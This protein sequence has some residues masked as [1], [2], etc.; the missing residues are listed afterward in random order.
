MRVGR[1]QHS[2]QT[3]PI[4][5]ASNSSDLVAVHVMTVYSQE[6]ERAVYGF[7][8]LPH[9]LGQ[10]IF[11]VVLISL[12]SN[13]AFSQSYARWKNRIQDSILGANEQSL[14][15]L[16]DL[17][18]IPDAKGQDSNGWPASDFT[19]VLD[20]R[21]AFAW[22]PEVTNV[23]PLKYS[24]SL[25]GHYRLTYTGQAL[26]LGV[27]N[28]KYDSATN[29]SSADYEIVEPPLG[30]GDLFLRIYFVRTKRTSESPLESGVT[31]IRLVRTEYA[32][33]P[34]QIFTNLWL[35]SIRKYSWASLRCMDILKTNNY[36]TPGSREEYPYRLNWET[37]RRL[38]GTG[39]LYGDLKSGVH[40]TCSLG[41]RRS[42]GATHAQGFVDQ[43]P[44]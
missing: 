43:Y 4:E 17:M 13:N 2:F 32:K 28:S 37:D 39:P 10:L 34:K 11:F 8:R 3:T 14:V 30:P 38:P 20:N 6:G 7:P 5:A 21:Y 33:A 24:T 35:D 36:A 31:D 42:I 29:T 16:V 18:S 27:I 26:V 23:D 19:L 9:G 40:G 41:I 1:L 12:L 22:A 44:G 25:A 15:N